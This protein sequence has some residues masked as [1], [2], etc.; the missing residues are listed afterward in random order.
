MIIGDFHT[1][2]FARYQPDVFDC[3][4]IPILLA[5]NINTLNEKTGNWTGALM[6]VTCCIFPFIEKRH[7]HEMWSF[8]VLNDKSISASIKTCERKG[9]A[10]ANNPIPL[11]LFNWDEETCYENGRKYDEHSQGSH[12]AGLEIEKKAKA[13]GIAVR[14]KELEDSGKINDVVAA[15]A[16]SMRELSTTTRAQ[17]AFAKNFNRRKANFLRGNGMAGNTGDLV[18][19]PFEIKECECEKGRDY[20]YRFVLAN[21][22]GGRFSFSDYGEIRESFRS[23]IRKQYSLE[24]PDVNPRSLEID[25]ADYSMSDGYV[26]GRVMVLTLS[27]EMARYDSATRTGRMSIKIGAN[28]FEDARRWIR[29]NIEEFAVKNCA[30][31]EG[32]IP[33]GARFSIGNEVLKED[34]R[35]EI[36]FKTE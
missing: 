35:L 3:S 24:H 22:S 2:D 27:V 21:K 26:K 36:E 12:S 11:L 30:M 18:D 28:Q 25:F 32:K 23:A 14:L 9:E 17:T 1:A 29:K 8:H 7:N 6:G 10:T 19:Q 34:G 31:I 33:K 13:Y 4:G 15:N 5:E 20:T 16:L